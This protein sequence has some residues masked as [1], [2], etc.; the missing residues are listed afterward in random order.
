MS[1]TLTVYRRS[2]ADTS[3]LR[4][5]A[6][7]TGGVWRSMSAFGRV[8]VIRCVYAAENHFGGHGGVLGGYGVGR[9]VYAAEFGRVHY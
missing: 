6:T 7:D 4:L 8:K 1:R 5:T 3:P 2:F 9:G